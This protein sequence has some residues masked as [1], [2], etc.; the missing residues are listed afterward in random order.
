MKKETKKKSL[1]SRIMNFI[2]PDWR[3]VYTID[4]L[5]VEA[6]E[7]EIKKLKKENY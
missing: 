4:G 5:F 3:N 6:L 1:I 2:L 7:R